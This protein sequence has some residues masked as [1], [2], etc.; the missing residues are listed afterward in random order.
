MACS[1]RRTI[2]SGLVSILR[3]RR[4]RSV[5]LNC[6]RFS[7]DPPS[8]STRLMAGLRLAMGLRPYGILTALPA[9][10]QSPLSLR[11]VGGQPRPCDGAD[12]PFGSIAPFAA[13]R[14]ALRPGSSHCECCWAE[15]T[16][17]ARTE[18][19]GGRSA[20]ARCEQ[21]QVDQKNESHKR[22]QRRNGLFRYGR[23]S[24]KPKLQH[25]E[26]EERSV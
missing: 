12:D 24:G 22:S 13:T 14:K 25:V 21:N 1:M 7:V 10:P 5:K 15:A 18:P 9:P 6:D 17:L 26:R 23:G 3:M 4:I 16:R 19:V 2:I 11:M 20:F 8:L